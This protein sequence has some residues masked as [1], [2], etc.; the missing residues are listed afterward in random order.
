MEQGAAMPLRGPRLRGVKRNAGW[1]L[2]LGRAPV[3]QGLNRPSPS[4]TCRNAGPR[5]APGPI[6]NAGRATPEAVFIAAQ[7][8]YLYF[9]ANASRAGAK[10]LAAHNR[11]AHNRNVQKWRRTLRQE[12]RKKR[13]AAA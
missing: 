7:S 5:P 13:S 12:R 1:G 10:A 8:R 9:I 2:P 6:A 4:N 3:Q 11:A